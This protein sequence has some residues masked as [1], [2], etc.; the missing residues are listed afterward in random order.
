MT[1]PRLARRCLQ[2]V[3]WPVALELEPPLGSDARRWLGK[4]AMRNEDTT[5]WCPSNATFGSDVSSPRRSHPASSAAAP[6]RRS[7]ARPALARVLC[8]SGALVFVSA[9]E[10][11][12]QE[13]PSEDAMFGATPAQS[14]APP[15]A[16]AENA[17]Q[18]QAA[19]TTQPAESQ[20]SQE[21][22]P[23]ASDASR[24]ESILGGS[25]TPMFTQE[26]A[27]ED[28][29]KIGGRIY[30]RAQGAG[31]QGQRVDRYGFSTPALVDAYFDARPNDRVR[32]YVLG[33]M[34]Y[35]PTL[36]QSGSSGGLA[37]S[38]SGAT[39]GTTQL[40]A[41]GGGATRGPHVALDQLWLRFDIDRSVFVTAGKQHVRWGTA[42][43][44]T[45]TDYLHLRH[46]N[47]LDVLDARS[48]T[49]LVKLHVPVESK[50]WNF[51]AYGLTESGSA[52]PALRD[53]AGALR[54]EF[55][56]GTAELG[57]GVF[58]HRGEKAKF[59]ADLSTAIGDVDLYGEL[60]VLDAG[61][62]DRV[63][64]TPDAELPARVD[65]P[66]WQS[67]FDAARLRSGQVIDALY[68]VYRQSGYRAQAVVG[69]TYTRNYNDNDTF[70]VGVEYFHNPLGYSSPVSY[71]G[72]LLPH[73]QALENPATF[74]YLG[75][76]YAAVYISFP[77]PFSLDLHSFTLS[78]LGNLSD[79]SFTTRF[80]YSLVLLTHLRFE[81][82][83]SARYGESHGEFR[84]GVH[85][86]DLD[87]VKFSR[88]PAIV[89]FGVGLRLD[90]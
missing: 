31:L 21:K 8:L 32:G 46:R 19:E 64:A 28:P 67:P 78:T 71:P 30:L 29:L 62:V 3:S 70:S 58:A 61:A 72:L 34:S 84:L 22:A 63:R 79:L 86:L 51:Y 20:A 77:S 1:L 14:D 55:V 12:A 5:A 65:A 73:G 80:D 81:A 82:F 35:D 36:A 15:A 57:L 47:P 27:P 60:A 44:W 26:T 38:V 33:R 4:K 75:R 2:A 40:S 42:R 56:L 83:A 90:I 53:V 74:F 85:E 69:A 9:S 88:A 59:A 7:A 24:D 37:S 23:A 48:G 11:R 17:A 89:D 49:T 13:R 50:S 25:D 87:G 6:A 18:R 68:P 76:H 10:L 43:F 45:P 39:M 52:T 41:I 54:A 16:A 66:S